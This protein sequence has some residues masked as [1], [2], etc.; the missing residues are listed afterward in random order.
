MTH[1]C[2]IFCF[3]QTYKR[4]SSSGFLISGICG[5]DSETCL[6]V[7]T[8]IKKK[9][10]YYWN[11]QQS[12]IVPAWLNTKT[13]TENHFFLQDRK[14]RPYRTVSKKKKIKKWTNL[15]SYCRFLGNSQY[16][17]FRPS[18]L[19]SILKVKSCCSE[20]PETLW[21]EKEDQIRKKY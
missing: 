4:S 2:L 11:I 5:V 20:I 16:Q 15:F 21:H 14:R 18:S 17:C 19:H 12:R 10:I 8:L 7:L 1:F 9:K 6:L 3:C 13:V